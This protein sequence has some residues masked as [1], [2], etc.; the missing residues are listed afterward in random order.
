MKYFS[1]APKKSTSMQNVGPNVVSR[2]EYDEKEQ[3]SIAK[4]EQVQVNFFP[5]L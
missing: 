2:I 5:K 4:E 1:S 3:E